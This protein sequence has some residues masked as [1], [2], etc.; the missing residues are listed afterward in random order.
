MMILLPLMGQVVLL[1]LAG[2]PHCV[3]MCGPLIAAGGRG[4]RSDALWFFAGRA[5]TYTALGVL[6]GALGAW[7]LALSW[8]GVVV[9]LVFVVVAA[10]QLLGWLPEPPWG[11]ALA[12]AGARAATSRRRWA[13]RYVLGG[14]AGFMPCGLVY[15]A[16]SVALLA[17]HPLGGAV[18]M[19]AFAVGTL[20]SFALIR[21]ALERIGGLGQGPRVALAL[22]MVTTGVLVLM[23]RAPGGPLAATPE[24]E[25]EPAAAPHHW[26]CLPTL[27]PPSEPRGDVLPDAVRGTS[28]PDDGA[29]I[30]GALVGG[31]VG[32]LAVDGAL[33]NDASGNDASGND[34]AGNDAAGNDASGNDASGNDASGNDVPVSRDG[35]TSD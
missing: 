8:V 20:P 4:A 14:A 33:G 10:G 22:A 2:S 5:T 28:A 32:G 29:P 27:P 7:L 25:A 6:A 3:G 19:F 24:L 34:A 13:R 11:A 26:L 21:E 9:S 23:L 12:Q 16:M 30:D 35:A 17:G 1:A 18:V 31:L 15:G